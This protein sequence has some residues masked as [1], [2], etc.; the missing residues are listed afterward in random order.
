VELQLP[1][2]LKEPLMHSR[3]LRWLLI[4][5]G[6]CASSRCAIADQPG[7]AE[8]LLGML[9][10]PVWAGG[11]RLTFNYAG[12]FVR[13]LWP[14]EWSGRQYPGWDWGGEIF[15]ADVVNGFGHDL[16]GPSLLV[17]RWFRG[18]SGPWRP[19]LQAGFGVLYSDAYRDPGQGQ[20]GEAVEFRSSVGLGIH[21]PFWKRWS[22][23]GELMF[24]HI[25]DGGISARN[26][27]VSALGIGIGLARGW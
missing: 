20:L 18:E 17:R 26:K 9:V 21:S 7:E 24:N 12:V 4:G 16:E 6:L 22:L 2:R 14:F 27:G 10:S 1:L 3:V 25:S 19:Y 23:A 8:A 15:A 11:P 5:T 13:N